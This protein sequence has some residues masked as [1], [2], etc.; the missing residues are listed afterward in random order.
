MKIS[1]V[2]ER[3][4]AAVGSIRA[5]SAVHYHYFGLTLLLLSACSIAT[6]RSI[7]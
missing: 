2:W 7:D 6:I 5:D 1:E 4:R 3:L